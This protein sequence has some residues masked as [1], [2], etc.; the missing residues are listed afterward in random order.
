[1]ATPPPGAPPDSLLGAAKGLW[2]ELPGLVS[3]RVELLSLELERAGLALVQ[4]MVLVIAAGILGVTAWLALCGG[5]A[6]LLVGLGLPWWASLCIVLAV[7]LLAAWWAV[8]R[9]R[10]LLPLLRLPATRRRLMF[11]P[12]PIPFPPNGGT[13]LHS[14]ETSHARPTSGNTLHAA[15]A[16]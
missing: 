11:S 1:M 9:V 7:N 3:G 15:H 12:S 10:T 14:H 4:I 13:H 2:Q 16:E 6:A 5:V 8:G